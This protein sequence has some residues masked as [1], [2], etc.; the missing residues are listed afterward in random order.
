[1]ART[2]VEAGR[3]RQFTPTVTHK[4]GDLAYNGG[5]F[6]VS[7]DDAVFQ[8]VAPSAAARDHM[9]ILD[10]VWDLPNN[11][12]DASLVNSGVKV[13]A[14]PTVRATSLLLYHNAA[15][16]SAAAVVIGRTWATA[17]AGATLVRVAL[18]ED[19]AY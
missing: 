14:D 11:A 12:F 1:M 9:L 4:K 5:F 16:L 2:F 19:N 17:A 10:G 15:S 6:G 18:F 7:Q 8:T 3:R 13:Y